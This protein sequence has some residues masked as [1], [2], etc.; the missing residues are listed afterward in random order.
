MPASA[1][2]SD[3]GIVEA[4]VRLSALVQQVLAEVADGFGLSVL[5]SR[6]L[7]VLRDREPSMARLGSLLGLDKSST[8]GLV[9][10]AQ[11]KGL[12]CRVEVPEDRRAFRMV[13]TERGRD[14]DL[15]TIEGDHYAGE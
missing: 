14:L 4:L 3:L 10:R 7:G 11:R 8:T 1:P 13:L 12:V 5:Q 2:P 9:D 6:L 15:S